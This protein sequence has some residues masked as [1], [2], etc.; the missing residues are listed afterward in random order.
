MYR[1]R[2]ISMDVMRCSLLYTIIEIKKFL[3][4]FKDNQNEI[5]MAFEYMIR[6]GKLLKLGLNMLA[7][8]DIHI[9]QIRDQLKVIERDGAGL[10]KV[11]EVLA[12]FSQ[13]VE[14]I[15]DPNTHG[16]P[17]DESKL[18]DKAKNLK[19]SENTYVEQLP[20]ANLEVYQQIQNLDQSS[21]LAFEIF[22]KQVIDSR[23]NTQNDL[24]ADTLYDFNLKDKFNSS[25]D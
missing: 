10:L 11:C 18:S 25:F 23:A 21:W 4:E 16:Q 12:D 19:L 22:Q 14:Q 5:N 3:L 20:K 1:N 2:D 17:L 6:K 9:K 7:S 24:E 15:N 8:K 13:I